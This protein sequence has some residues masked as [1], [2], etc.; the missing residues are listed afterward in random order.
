MPFEIVR[1]DIT[2]MRVGSIVN[3]ANQRL[4]Q[5]GGVCG[6]IF[7]AAGAQELQAECDG[8]GH[9]DVGSAV[10]TGGYKLPAKYVIHAVG[11]I[12]QGGNH[13]EEALLSSC[14][15]N[16]LHLAKER[17]LSSIAFPLISSGIFGYPKDEALRVAV[18]AIAEFLSEH[19]MNVY[20]VVFDRASFALGDK[21]F[22]SIKTYIDNN[23]VD[24]HTEHSRQ[25]DH[26]VLWFEE[27]YRSEW[28]IKT[29]SHLSLSDVFNHVGESF[30]E[31]LLRLID[32]S[33]K[34]DPEVYK[35]A[36]IDRRLF[37]KIRSNPAYKPSKNTALALAVALELNLDQTEDLLR[38][39]GYALSPSSRFDL[40]V[41]YFINEENYNIYEI[42][43]ALFAFDESLL[44]A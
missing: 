32:E 42:N 10:I 11:P 17:G 29:A 15:T 3:A 31:M 41:E 8:I 33:G 13:N 38:S 6:A 1:N 26:S 24:E 27:E 14:Y 28:P 43:E 7:A 40:I 5:G 44:G 4:K 37:S 21:L 16:S 23:Y 19:E 2:R 25:N 18:S 35:R 30:S 34:T 12:W 20:L 9:C 22:K 36:N 39:A